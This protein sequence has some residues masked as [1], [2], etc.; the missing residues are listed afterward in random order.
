MKKYW[1]EFGGV[2]LWKH[3]CVG[4]MN[5]HKYSTSPKMLAK[6]RLSSIYYMLKCD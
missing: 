3:V 1:D 6:A 5:V 2:A 4:A